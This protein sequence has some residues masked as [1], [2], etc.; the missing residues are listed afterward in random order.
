MSSPDHKSEGRMTG[1]DKALV[2]KRK[3]SAKMLV[4]MFPKVPKTATVLLEF[5]IKRES[6]TS[7]QRDPL[8]HFCQE[9]VVLHAQE[10][11][12][13]LNKQVI[14]YQDVRDMIENLHA[15]HM[16]CTKKNPDNAKALGHIIRKLIIIIGELAATLE[17]IAEVPITDWL[18]IGDA[19][20]NKLERIS[21]PEQPPFSSFIPKMRDFES[22]KLLGAGGFGAVYLARFKPGNFNST[23]KLVATDRFSKFK[24]AAMDKVV[25]SVIRNPFL[26]K[27]YCCFCV[28]EAYVTIM[29]YIPGVDLM[30]VVTK[31]QFLEIDAV[32]IIMAQLILALEHLH[33]RGFLHRDIKVSNMLIMPGG[34]VKVIDFD[35]TKICN[36]HFSKRPLRG[37]FRRT[38]FEFNDGESAGTIPYMAPE[39]LKRRP[40]GRAVDWWSSGIV[41]YKMMTG[42]VPFRGKTKQTLRDK[43]VSSPLKWPR[44]DEHPHSATTPA[45]DM[46]YRMLKKNPVQR[47][48]SKNYDDL[49][50]HQ[51]FDGFDWNQL[52]QK[53]ELCDI[54]S[55][56]EL[57]KEDADRDLSINPDSDDR[58]EHQ[59]IEEMTDI[60][61]E[62]QKPLLCFVS[63]SFKKLMTM[64][65]VSGT[66][67]NATKIFM[68]MSGEKSS[69][70]DYN[71]HKPGHSVKAS[72]MDDRVSRRSLAEKIDIIIYRK[73]KLFRYWGYGFTLRVIT[74]EDSSDFIYVETVTRNGPADRAQLLPLDVIMF[75]NGTS[76]ADL[77]LEKVRDMIHNTTDQMVVSV[78][79]SS[80]YR[81]LT[82]RQDMLSILR[83]VPRDSVVLQGGGSYTC[84]GSNPYGLGII[85]AS[86]WDERDKKTVKVYVLSRV[87][88]A[89]TNNKLLFP[90][91]VVTQVDGIR[92]DSGTIQNILQVI[93]L[94]EKDLTLNIIPI[95][96]F[97][98]NPILLNKLRETAM[99]DALLPSKST[100]AQIEKEFEETSQEQYT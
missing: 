88:T 41:M 61:G 73:K 27:Y 55:I 57:I 89:P 64:V 84:G 23:V 30:R 19:I 69:G 29:E 92:L 75:V 15:L 14:D 40:Y 51:F 72:G 38:P 86:T 25:A 34:R 58:R 49:K 21:F 60:S 7:L 83:T 33:L 22:L 48:G 36:A 3:T 26:V 18:G 90:G 87:D 5:F 71:F 35:T 68:E 94:G 97:R 85:D 66:Q 46:A 43:I 11:L 52:Y 62:S 78:M 96:P 1:K 80:V 6:N 47:L 67:V 63:P 12:L 99:S 20:V 24:Q 82:T 70:V 2:E 93:Y 79:A 65:K 56:Q 9:E 4:S 28:K 59:Q 77:S 53:K 8:A 17:K 39:I 91:D 95:S 98:Q 37:Y 50:T 76:V 100:P 31:D 32:Q 81:M 54:P 74:G 44:R 10:C 45:K 13:R 16:M 42:R